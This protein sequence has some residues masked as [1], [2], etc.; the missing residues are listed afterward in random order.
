[1]EVR[2]GKWCLA[3]PVKFSQCRHAIALA[4]ESHGGHRE[5]RCE[6]HAL[7]LGLSGVQRSSRINNVSAQR[8]RGTVGPARELSLPVSEPVRRSYASATQCDQE[9][10]SI[11]QMVHE[12]SLIYP[13]THRL[14]RKFPSRQSCTM[15]RC[16]CGPWLKRRIETG[17]CVCPRRAAYKFDANSTSSD[18]SSFLLP[19]PGLL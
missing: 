2:C 14:G 15:F 10:C 16:D 7:G 17:S 1:M 18:L 5:T 13:E 9:P 19:E 11:R 4:A 12:G 3:R 8:R 6:R